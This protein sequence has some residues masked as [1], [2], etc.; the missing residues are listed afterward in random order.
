MEHRWGE[1]VVVDIPVRLMAQ[2]PFLAIDG[3]LVDLSTS[4]GCISVDFEFRVLSIVQVVFESRLLKH[5]RVT[6]YVAR[7]YKDRI[8]IEWCEFAP[9]TITDLMR[10][11]TVRSFGNIGQIE[12]AS[13]HTGSS[14]A[15]L[16]HRN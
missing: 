9:A 6:A 4:G 7:R 8:G 13:Q 5:A 11:L 12:R 1:R 10:S 14:A 16:N 2:H 3:W 15:R